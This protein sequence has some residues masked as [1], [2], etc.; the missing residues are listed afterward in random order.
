MG[1]ASTST[2]PSEQFPKHRL[3]SWKEIATHLKRD[4]TTVQRWE[5]REGMP[6]HRHVHDKRGTVYAYSSELEA[7][8]QSRRLCLEEEEEGAHQEAP[9]AAVS[10]HR[11]NQ[12]DRVHRWLVLSG[13][14][15]LALVGIIYLISR[16]HGVG[17]TR[18]KIT[19]VAVLPL[20]NLSGDPM[21]EYFA[22]GMTDAVIGRLS[23]IRG[24]RVIS[25]TSVMR[26]K[27]AHMSVP[28]IAKSLGVDAI[29][30]GSVLREGGHV[31]VHAQ[32]I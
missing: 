26:F 4:M 8:L 21:Q 19:S 20:K 27:D 18:S 14:A 11:S 24:L 22:D 32:L 31:R 28:E 7:W 2:P 23:L 9:V 30:E 25:R 13:I 12:R 3:D 29:V 16:S 15:V 6:V 10:S 1:E 17:A 5:K